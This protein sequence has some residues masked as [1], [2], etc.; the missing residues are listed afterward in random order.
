MSSGR[1]KR[2]SKDFQV[3]AGGYC[4]FRVKYEIFINR[5]LL[6]LRERENFKL[7]V[8]LPNVDFNNR[9]LIGA[10]EQLNKEGLSICLSKIS[11]DYYTTLFH[12]SRGFLTHRNGH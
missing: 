3:V 12:M 1:N 7:F 4:K 6:P 5:N 10:Y 11:K 9:Q 8:N 2:Y